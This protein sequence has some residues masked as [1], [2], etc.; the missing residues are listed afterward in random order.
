MDD[1]Y[2]ENTK[3]FV[4][5]ENNPQIMTALSHHLGLSPAL[6]FTDVYS[7]TDPSLLSLLPRPCFALLFIAPETPSLIALRDAEDAQL[8]TYAGSSAA[9][10]ILWY[11]Q[12]IRHAC[13]LIGLLHCIT[14]DPAAGLIMPDSAL[15]K[16]RE[17]VLGLEPTA[18]AQY[19]YDS[20][21]L[22]AAH[23]QF[24]AQGDTVA[25]DAL[26]YDDGH[27][28]IAYVKGSDGHLYE[29][30]GRRKGP[31]DRGGLA[32]D[33]DVLSEAAL[34]KGPLRYVEAAE[35]AGGEGKNGQFSCI[36][37]GITPEAD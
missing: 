21:M 32:E 13:G 36:A 14:N 2:T 11:R 29:L 22:E 27:A 9:E 7:L 23:A 20:E 28:F 1:H 33:E 10:P 16:L 24:A 34:R 12:T 15:A 37:L 35:K 18:R 26:T 3:T 25:P 19:L 17:E 8:P 30:E 6:S 5:L 4:P 31:L